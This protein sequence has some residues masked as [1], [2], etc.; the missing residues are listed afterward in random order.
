MMKLFPLIL[1]FLPFSLLAQHQVVLSSGDT[2]EVRKATLK[3]DYI[4]TVD[5]DTAIGD[6]LKRRGTP[7]V[8]WYAAQKKINGAGLKL[9]QSRTLFYI[10]LAC[11]VLGGGIIGLSQVSKQPST[12]NSTIYFGATVMGIGGI[13]MVTAVIPIGRAGIELQKVSFAKSH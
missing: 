5:G 4:V 2:I 12:R 10:G 6:I 9:E 8:N 3:G 1:C 11:Q 13:V 7:T